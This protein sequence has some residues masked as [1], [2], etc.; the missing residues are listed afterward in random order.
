ML[1]KAKEH[2]VPVLVFTLV[3]GIVLGSILTKFVWGI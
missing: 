2:F 3:I 1:E